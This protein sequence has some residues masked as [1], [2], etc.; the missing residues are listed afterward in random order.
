[1]RVGRSHEPSHA[2]PYLI[3]LYAACVAVVPAVAVLPATK[4]TERGENRVIQW[5]HER[6]VLVVFA[7]TTARAEAQTTSRKKGGGH[8]WIRVLWTSGAE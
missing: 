4:R 7:D 3:I 1:M 6:E 5:F 2:T 8:D